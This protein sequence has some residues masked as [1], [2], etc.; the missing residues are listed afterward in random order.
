MSGK[1]VDDLRRRFEQASDTAPFVSQSPERI[2]GLRLMWRGEVDQAR[3]LLSR[4]LAQADAHGEAHSYALLRLHLCQLELRIGDCDAAGRL[5]GEWAKSSERVM[6]PMYERCRALL[7]AARGTPIEAERWA[8]RTLERAA[9]AGTNWDRL[10]ALR[11]GGIAGL[12]TG[13]VARAAD[14]LR[15]VWS[16]REDEGVDEPGVF[17]IAPDL[18][19]ALVELGELE[20]AQRV[21]DRL[22]EL[23]TVQAHPWGL[24]TSTRCSGLLSLDDV[25]AAG[26]QLTAAADIYATLGLRH[27]Q[28]RSLLSLGRAQRRLRKWGAAAHSLDDAVALFQGLGARG[29][30]EQARAERARVGGR[31]P[32]VGGGLTATERRAAELAADGLANKE[33]AAALFVSVRTVEVH[34]KHAYAKLGIRSRTQLARRLSDGD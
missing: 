10:E 15:E 4:L 6:W 31:K 20:E 34:L 25:D 22:R 2:A 18:V 27:D 19:E 24:A 30:A 28:A 7:A 29:W 1:P 13:D 14:A 33:I 32:R 17:P 5:L 9:A 3:T 16:H 21:T 12:L 11:A 23:S 8:A 26:V